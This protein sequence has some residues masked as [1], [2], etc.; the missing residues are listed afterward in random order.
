MSLQV[1]SRHIH[2]LFIT[3]LE[4]MNIDVTTDP[5]ELEHFYTSNIFSRVF[6]YLV[7]KIRA[8]EYVTLRATPDGKLYVVVSG[9]G[10]SDYTPHE[11]TASD[12]Y[13]STN[14][15]EEEFTHVSILVEDN[16]AVISMRNNEGVWKG[17]I[18]LTLGWHTFDFAGTGIRIKN[19]VSGS[20]AKFTIITWR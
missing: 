11:G 12:S 5:E 19:R 8:N 15:F 2:V 10:Y 13:D 9:G 20:N 16:E 18:P 1:K 3:C 4:R 6:A 7:A 14:T 17:D